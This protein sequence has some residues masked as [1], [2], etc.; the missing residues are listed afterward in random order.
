MSGAIHP[1]TAWCK[2]LLPFARPYRHRIA[3]QVGV[4]FLLA[5]IAVALPW[6]TKIAIDTVL[7]EGP[8]PSWI[9]WLAHVPGWGGT[10]GRLMLLASFSVLLV[11]ARAGLTAIQQVGWRTT[12]QQMSV[13]LA[14]K[15]LAAVQQRPSAGATTVTT[16]DTIRRITFDSRAVQIL[17]LTVGLGAAGAGMNL[18]LMIVIT[19][20]ID[21]RLA[22]LAFGGAVPMLAL[23]TRQMRPMMQRSA[24]LAHADGMV[25]TDLE[26]S[27]TVLPETQSFTAEALEQGRF[28]QV[29][30]QRF[31]AIRSTQRSYLRYELSIGAFTAMGT[32]L[33]FLIGGYSALDSTATVGDL[34]VLASY[35][36]ALL[37]PITTIAS[38]G[39]M[40]S[41]AR[42]SALRV[43]DILRADDALPESPTPQTIPHSDRGAR[44]EMH[45][46]VAGYTPGRPVLR[47]INLV[48]EPGEMVA[49]VGRTGSGKST[50]VSLIP[51]LFDP[52]SGTVAINGVEVRD[53]K[54]HDV[55]TNVAMVRQDTILLPGTVAANIAYGR[56]GASRQEIERAAQAASADEFIQALSHGYDTEL[57]THG[58]TLSGGQQ[59][60]LSIA[61]AVLKGAAVLLLD[62][63]TSSLDAESEASVMGAIERLRSTTTIIVIAHRLSTVLRADKIVVLEGGRVAEVGSHAELLAA[64]DGYAR[65]HQR[66]LRAAER[67]ETSSTTLLPSPT[68]ER[69][70]EH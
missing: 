45:Q 18:A 2:A 33:V 8:L 16:G 53:A 52:W 14:G 23:I 5:I 58:T 65:V 35:V 54:L 49:L 62:E 6:P 34:V 28:E 61:R 66:I 17:V 25:T 12:G 26:R 59:Q 27:L 36:A 68:R 43:I 67:G 44:V 15:L 7:G 56:P 31:T 39:Q 50:L 69:H 19:T 46:V 55:R 32:A 47:G 13:D 1:D 60:R 4:S 38:L 9:G 11:I 24:A 57:G 29:V 51:R 48:I 21:W 22:A 37:G 63:P 42:A 41:I 70:E 64:G 20:T 3:R 30:A 10:T 40:Y